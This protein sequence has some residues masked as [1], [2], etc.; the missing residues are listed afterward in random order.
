MLCFVINAKRSSFGQNKVLY[1]SLF[2]PKIHISQ[3]VQATNCRELNWQTRIFHPSASELQDLDLLPEP[4]AWAYGH[5]CSHQKTWLP[6]PFC[7][8]CPCLVGTDHTLA[9]SFGC[10]TAA[11]GQPEGVPVHNPA[12]KLSPQ[13]VPLQAGISP[14]GSWSSKED[15][16]CYRDSLSERQC[17]FFSVFFLQFQFHLGSAQGWYVNDLR[18]LTWIKHTRIWCR[19]PALAMQTTELEKAQASRTCRL[20]WVI[21]A[22][23]QMQITQLKSHA[24]PT[25]LLTK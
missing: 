24:N 12:S 9:S 1:I 17:P 16:F 13:A 14:R 8:P 7:L 19:C 18:Y 15:F 5:H 4:S 20:G 23:S 2:H 3:W 11:K 25:F 22:G 21:A 6:S 10:S